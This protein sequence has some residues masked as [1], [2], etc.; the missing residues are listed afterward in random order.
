MGNN[1]KGKKQRLLKRGRLTLSLWK[2]YAI[3]I[4]F[5]TVLITSVTF[6]SAG[7]LQ[8]EMT[9][10]IQHS[11][12][13]SQENVDSVLESLW[14]LSVQMT[15]RT[16]VGKFAVL[17]DNRSSEF[18]GKLW[19]IKS[20]FSDY[21]NLM[22]HGSVLLYFDSIGVLLS[23]N[24]VCTDAY[25]YYGT[26]FRFGDWDR[27]KFQASLE[28]GGSKIQ[29]LEFNRMT[30]GNT[31]YEG[32]FFQYKF[33]LYNRCSVTAY[34]FVEKSYLDDL[35]A[36]LDAYD[37]S[38]SLV[39]D[40]GE[41]VYTYGDAAALEDG[42]IQEE[43]YLW[44]ST[45]SPYGFSYRTMLPKDTAYGRVRLLIIVS[46]VLICLSVSGALLI[47]LYICL[48]NS[49]F[50]SNIFRTSGQKTTG[51]N[52]YRTLDEIVSELKMNNEEL[53]HSVQESRFM[54]RRDFFQ[55]LLE[56][57]YRTDEE[58]ELYA[59]AAG[60]PRESVYYAAAFSLDQPEPPA[61]G[62]GMEAL[63]QARNR[64]CEE[65]RELLGEYG[66]AIP[67]GAERIR[68]LVR[69]GD[70]NA[71]LL[72]EEIFLRVKQAASEG[73]FCAS[74]R[75]FE[76]A[77]PLS[78]LREEEEALHRLLNAQ[79]LSESGRDR[80]LWS[81]RGQIPAADDEC[82]LSAERMAELAAALRAGN[83][84]MA[85]AV[86]QRQYQETA[87][88][89]GMRAQEDF[90]EKLR[91]LFREALPD[92]E[93]TA[94]WME[95]LSMGITL[96]S[97]LIRR[98]R[99]ACQASGAQEPELRESSQVRKFRENVV[100]YIDQDLGNSELSLKYLADRFGFAP[101]YFSALFKEYM[102]MNLSTYLDEKRMRLAN[103]L[104]LESDLRLEEISRRCGYENSNTFR[105]AYKKY[106]GVNPSQS[107]NIR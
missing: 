1:N 82:G 23:E 25:A 38:P 80:L 47:A 34:L 94:R 28:A 73:G 16:E 22:Q 99:V 84:A 46:I 12:E 104:I 63:W 52:I 11:V 105:R 70:G 79:T 42:S 66:E 69:E 33:R 50:L 20:L 37:A 101:T 26:M 96:E 40:G 54:L 89:A 60:I 2:Y 17:Q 68:V 55:K 97:L 64:C 100:T 4:I 56:N 31:V 24:W 44:F 74:G 92:S 86:F 32:V 91:G 58:M 71:R 65:A 21:A 27:E 49:R 45:K 3:L 98:I 78:R 72:I 53:Q 75:A 62:D 18:Y 106:F 39:G 43:D 67:Q 87:S 77:A 61:G 76:E 95:L 83:E 102:N 85:E 103:Q 7:L 41:V 93:D 15:G 88:R 30:I 6:W 19:K 48:R 13:Y 90:L 81:L 36:P 9:A 5:P 29:L 59:N 10:N 51:E 8:K 107:K 57:Q 35:F 14:D